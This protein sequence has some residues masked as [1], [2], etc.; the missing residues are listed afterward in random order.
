MIKTEEKKECLICGKEGEILY[1]NL[2]DR[3]FGVPGRYGF[4]TCRDCEIIWQSPRPVKEEIEK[5]YEN[6]Y[7]HQAPP[8]FSERIRRF[9][10]FRDMLRNALLSEVWGYKQFKINRWW[11]P[12]VARVLY[13]IPP[14]RE[15]ARFKM[16]VF[17]L[18]FVGKGRL[19]EIGCGTGRYLGFMKKMGWDVTGIEM[20]KKACEIARQ[21]FLIN[22]IETD[23]ESMEFKPDSFDAI[24]ASHVIEHLYSPVKVIKECYNAL[25]PGGIILIATPNIFSFGHKIFKGYWIGLDPSRHIYLFSPN[26]LKKILEESGFKINMVFTSSKQS[27]FVFE[28]SL[29]FKMSKEDF[30]KA[31]RLYNIGRFLNV[32]LKWSGEEIIIMGMKDGK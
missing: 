14:L 25:S 11:A 30:K 26:S 20:D 27:L 5:C 29:K 10:K 22:I 28:E 15:R 3:L 12:L 9:A 18:P 2:E 24:V 32:F 21:N 13:F 16:G 7:T 23:I 19:L 6:Y 4:R 17:L 1:E 31:K 8:P